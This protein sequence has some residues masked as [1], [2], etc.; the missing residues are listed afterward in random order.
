MSRRP[1]YSR[2][3]NTPPL[4]PLS[5]AFPRQIIVV[6]LNEAVIMTANGETRRLSTRD[7]LAALQGQ[8]PPILCHGPTVARRLGVEPTPALDVLELYAFAR[9]AQFCLP[10]PAGVAVALGLNRPAT[11]EDQARGLRQV[12]EKLLTAMGDIGEL[13]RTLS[14][15]RDALPIART[16]SNGGWGWGPAV[17][18]ALEKAHPKEDQ[19]R[20]RAGLDVWV[21]LPSW[22]EN[23]PEPP[24]ENFAVDPAEARERL[25]QL[26]GAG[27][28]AR[29]QQADYAS[30]VCPAFGPRDDPSGPNTVVAEAGT[31]VGKT[32]GYIAPAS[33]W[34][35]RNGGTV[36]ISTY[37]RNLQRQIDDELDRLHP[38][39]AVKARRVVIR[40]GRENYLCL[41]N[42]EE[43]LGRLATGQ[44]SATA[45]GL[46]ARWAGRTRTGDIAGGDFPTWLADLVGW[47]DTLGLA[48]R[49]GECIYSSCTHYSKCFIERTVR[50]AR[51]ADIV[52]ANHALVM[53]QAALGGLD[54]GTVPTRLV[55]DEG[56]H[57]FGAADSAFCAELS[58]RQG[59]ELRRWLLGAEGG[60]SSR[61]RGLARR[62]EDLANADGATGEALSALQD[63]ARCLP[64]PNWPSRIG[65]GARPRGPSEALLALIRQ[66]VY[67]RAKDAYGSYGLETD[68]LPPIDGLVDAARELEEALGRLSRPMKAL[69]ARLMQLLDEE[70]ASMDTALRQ[71][72]EATARGL[73]RR[74]DAEIDAWRS[75]LKTLY[76]EGDT[77]ASSVS[78]ITESEN[79]FVDWFSISR[80]QGRDVDAAM[81]RHWIDPTIPF[82]ET[83]AAP[84]H[85]VLVTSATL[86]DGTGDIETDWRAAEEVT[87][88][89]HL[90][91]PAIRA[92]SPSPFDYPTQTRVFVVTD[93]A[94]DD[95]GQVAAAYRELF[96]AAG[97][98]ALGLFTAIARLRAV[99]ERIAGP[100][101][102]AGLALLAQHV[103]RMDTA[104]L[105]EI[106][107]AEENTCLLGTDAIRDGVD[108]PGRALR[109]VVFDR[110]PWP[111]PTILHRARRNA[112]G[113]SAYDDR[114]TRLRLKQAYGRLTRRADDH[115]VFV[116]LDSRTPSRLLGAFPPGVEVRRVGLAEAVAETRSFLNASHRP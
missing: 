68:T 9:P 41:L 107:R 34:A 97:G 1:L 62:I 78:D 87:G 99:Q 8:P 69:I 32:L 2:L 60:G 70:A 26:V 91:R 15:E 33:L 44:A 101:E 73:R 23:A 77:G 55:F 111:R 67:A 11:L 88:A 16:M 64:G 39:P 14:H 66:Q 54:D 100:L 50:Q 51:R 18:E 65:N 5:P 106:F 85:G 35:E 71:R 104:S 56:H 116:L 31:G 6:G 27:A 105:I 92:A 63:A 12:V 80:E 47:R 109:L 49:R 37:T 76:A 83:V 72:I 115:G 30:A 48:D 10:T 102:D 103:D 114:I 25:I 45:L 17:I 90:A 36:W 57:L 19:P 20:P 89:V 46:I 7:A 61:A 74:A 4:T 13:D 112:F 24:P 42:M 110:V 58:G 22:A 96:L 84:A 94:R 59:A 38:D 95:A 86:R 81:H 82:T 52:V 93:V 79:I 75:M 113:G 21:R 53:A 98:G 28:E 29:P 108:V 43:A 3:M 40:K